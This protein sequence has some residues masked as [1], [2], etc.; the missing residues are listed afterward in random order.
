VRCHVGFFRHA[1]VSARSAP[2]IDG[3]ALRLLVACAIIR[4]NSQF[5]AGEK[6]VLILQGPA[7]N[8]GVLGHL[9]ARTPKPSAALVKIRTA[10]SSP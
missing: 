4:S 10:R 9:L 6:T 7:S 5:F 1:T 2:A 8:V 3:E